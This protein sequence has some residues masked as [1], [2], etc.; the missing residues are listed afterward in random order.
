MFGIGTIISALTSLGGG[1]L[2]A[3]NKSKDVSI[4]AIKSA[5]AI[6][7]SQVQAMSLW[8]G[9]PL[10]P[11]SIMCYGLAGWFFKAAFLDKVVA[12]AFGYNWSTDPLSGDLKDV[13][14]IVASGMFFSGIANIIKR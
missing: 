14:M 5:G 9:H 8:I 1:L 11:P 10:S 13:A 7:A 2:A 4:E 12:P 3:Y 6:A